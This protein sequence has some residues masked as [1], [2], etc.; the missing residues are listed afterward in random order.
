MY[1][2]I[3]EGVT[4]PTG[5]VRSSSG[6]TEREVTRMSMRFNCMEDVCFNLHRAMI[7]TFSVYGTVCAEC[8]QE[9]A[10]GDQDVPTNL[11]LPNPQWL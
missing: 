8:A 10:W 6:I 11:Y 9:R 2:L 5:R 4:L 7:H 3:R 1:S